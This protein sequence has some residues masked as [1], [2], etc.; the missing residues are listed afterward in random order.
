MY[1]RVFVFVCVHVCVRV[2]ICV[3]VWVCAFLC[4]RAYVCVCVWYMNMSAIFGHTNV[5]CDTP[6]SY[7]RTACV[8]KQK[9]KKFFIKAHVG[10]F[11]LCFPGH[12]CKR[13]QLSLQPGSCWPL[14]VCD[15]NQRVNRKQSHLHSCVSTQVYVSIVLTHMRTDTSIIHTRSYLM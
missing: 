11:P 15:W 2:C 8:L 9:K 1:V 14:S 7:T 5:L 13:T 4:V 6:T 12:L 10:Y 3:Y